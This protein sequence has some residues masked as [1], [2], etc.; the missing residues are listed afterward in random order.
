MKLRI[1]KKIIRSGGFPGMRISTWS[2]AW[3]RIGRVHF[4]AI[5]RRW[6]GTR[7]WRWGKWDPK[8]SEAPW[9]LPF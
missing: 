1:A 2:K 8:R 7:G 6:P 4:R 9:D 3:K 5:M